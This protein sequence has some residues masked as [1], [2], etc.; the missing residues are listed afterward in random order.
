MKTKIEL[1]FAEMLNG[2]REL[3]YSTASRLVLEVPDKIAENMHVIP[4]YV[5]S[6]YE[7][8]MVQNGWDVA[9]IETESWDD[10]AVIWCDDLNRVCL[11][12]Y[13]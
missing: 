2:K 3:D 13:C 11:I 7:N 10:H 4:S 12:R 8:P 9:G 1:T 6:M 5:F